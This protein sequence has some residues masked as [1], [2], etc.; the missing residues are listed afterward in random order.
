MDEYTEATS[1]EET[2]VDFAVKRAESI[3]AQLSGDLVVE[4]ETESSMG[5]GVPNIGDDANAGQ[6]PP[7]MG[8]ENGAAMQPPE[9][10]RGGNGAPPGINGNMG[11]KGAGNSSSSKDTIILSS[12]LLILLLGAIAFAHFFKRR[13]KKG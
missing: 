13:G 3:L 11:Q 2:L 6:Q 4:A 1:G 12:V 10:D 9:M 5:G 7:N 8:G